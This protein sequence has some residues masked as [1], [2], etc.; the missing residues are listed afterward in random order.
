M[1][2]SGHN[3]KVAVITMFLGQCHLANSY[4]KIVT[5]I[6]AQCDKRP[7]CAMLDV[8][9]GGMVISINEW[10]KSCVRP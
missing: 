5:T 6:Q 2:I 9:P 10:S 3:E 1:C 4:L 8:T 7:T